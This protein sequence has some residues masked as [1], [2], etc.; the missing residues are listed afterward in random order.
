MELTSVDAAVTYI[1]SFGILAPFVTFI[2]FFIH[3]IAPVFPYFILAG[4][5][6]M[7]FGFK[8]GSFL[9]WSG[10]LA[11]ACFEFYLIKIIGWQY[12][13]KWVKKHYKIDLKQVPN[14]YGFWAIL[15]ARI[16]PVVPTPLINILAPLSGVPFYIFLIASAIG[17]IP[18]AVVYAGLGTR[19]YASRDILGTTAILVLLFLAGYLGVKLAKKRGYV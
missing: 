12:P 19:F 3:G 7:V 15:L 6:G 1:R 10:A 11:G 17:K 5:A 18:T 9:A 8:M 13:Q 16:I 14:H 2:L 4:A